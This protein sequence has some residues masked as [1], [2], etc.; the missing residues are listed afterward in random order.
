MWKKDGRFRGL[1]ITASGLALTIGLAACGGGETESATL[2]DSATASS[3]GDAVKVVWW[4]SMG[5]NNGKVVDKL[6]ADFNQSQADIVVEP[7]FQ[8]TYGESLTKLFASL[9]SDSGP[10]I[11]QMNFTSSGPMID[12]G[13]VTPV[14][15]FIDAEQYDIGQL[16]PNIVGNYI[17]R[18]TLYSMPYNA[19][20]L[21]LYYNKDMFR[22]AGL[23]PE[24]PP[25]TFEE[26]MAAA[27]QL[28]K[29]GVYGTAFGSS[30]AWFI[31]QFISNQGA[32]LV[33]NGNGREDQ[34]TESLLDSEAAVRTFALWR[35]LVK[36][37][38][39]LN[40]NSADSHKAFLSEQAAMTL[41]S[42]AGLKNLLDGSEGKFE[43][44]TAF[45]PKPADAKE[46][47]VYVSGASLYI[48]NDRP[49]T[50]QQASWEF[51]KYLMEP[52]QQA[53]FHINTG[54]FPVP[55]ASY[56]EPDVID[57]LKKYPQFQTA[58]DQLNASVSNHA[59]RGA[60]I[61]IYPEARKITVQALEEMLNG[62]LEPEEATKQAADEITVKLQEY[63]DSLQR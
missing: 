46:G 10:A 17:Y 62:Q 3:K 60:I 55:K 28:T 9:G 47:G 20:N 52:K 22:D 24:T 50:E 34:A 44:G 58:I 8:G 63:I 59:S 53:Y 5:G 26:L 6:A 25:R 45:L 40:L 32:E 35:D 16:D 48:M 23:D 56:E 43:L 42:T 33:N 36:H 7:I 13:A 61:G 2:A 14:Q 39:G 11:M 31:E 12:T 19:S 49:E 27:Q 4:H 29:D 57:N 54:Y 1:Q 41:A 51:I 37:G 21:L 15:Q 38:Y 18:D 30:D